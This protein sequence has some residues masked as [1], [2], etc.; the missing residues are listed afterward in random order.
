[1]DEMIQPRES[2]KIMSSDEAQ[3]ARADSAEQDDQEYPGLGT[4]AANDPKNPH[5]WSKNRKLLLHI[6]VFLTSFTP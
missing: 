5:A 2:F 6:A 4:L 3:F 1:M